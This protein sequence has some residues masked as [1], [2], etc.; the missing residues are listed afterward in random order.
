MPELPEV[1]TMVR[2]IREAVVGSQ[3]REFQKCRCACKPISMKPGFKSIQKKVLN[4]TVISARRLAKRVILD[5]DNEHSFVIEP[6]MTGLMLLSDP[7]DR[8]HLRLEWQLQK[9]RTRTSLWFWDR[10][11]LGT[12]Q[13]LKKSELDLVLGPQKLGPDALTLT[14]KDLEQRCHRTSRAIKVALLDQKLVAGIGNLYASEILHLSRIHPE[15]PANELS[16]AELKA[17]HQATR[18]ILKA[19]IRYEGSTL[20]DGTYRNAL[21]KSGGYQNH[22]RVYSRAG[23][24][25]QTCQGAEIVRIVQAQRST[26]YCPCCQVKN[27]L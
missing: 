23:E 13:L 6:R 21:N 24:H 12:V 27:S 7:P 3:I 11:G 25:C 5:L 22:H 2:G 10:R 19:A 26:F 9:G 15:R 4:R 17:L 8:E 16:Q 20:G 14:L 1:E 18:K